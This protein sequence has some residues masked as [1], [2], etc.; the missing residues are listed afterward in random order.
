MSHP[1]HTLH[2]L[3]LNLVTDH[4]FGSAFLANPTAVLSEAGLTDITGADVS[5]VTSLVAEHV[6]APVAD[7]VENGLASLPTD[8]L[9]VNDLN[10][11]LA[12]LEVVATVAQEV[13][14]TA[15]ST[16]DF[17]LG[18]VSGVTEATAVSSS[19][20]ATADGLATSLAAATPVG[21]VTGAVAAS[22]GTLGVGLSSSAGAY[23]VGVG[24]LPL[25]APSFDSVGD[26]GSTLDS[27]VFS[28][29]SPVSSTATGYVDQGVDLAGSGVTGVTAFAG[30]HIAGAGAGL[31]E[32][33]AATGADVAG[34]LTS[35]PA[36]AAQATSVLPHVTAPVHLPA[37]LPVH[38]AAEL[39][40]LPAAA[41]VPNVPDT[42]EDTVSHATSVTGS[43]THG[44][45][46]DT[47]HAALPD[48]GDLSGNLLHTD[49]PLGH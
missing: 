11:A 23:G 30:D 10:S 4:A 26:L 40:H 36:V 22:A 32:T 46:L 37:D 3:V 25:S 7:A 12:H 16:S 33:V 45:L 29:A 18:S 19:F 20:G 28:D 27:D 43:V 49:L 13:P 42:V 9:G 35:V 47:A 39:P 41:A 5:E 6:P 31:G 24:S 44:G 34:H 2:S 8:A 21:D 14:A 17:A 1:I 48:T 38:L 15:A